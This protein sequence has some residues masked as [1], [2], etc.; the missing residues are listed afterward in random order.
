MAGHFFTV[1]DEQS[2]GI[3]ERI[4]HA[5]AVF[6]IYFCNHQFSA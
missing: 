5:P 2:V 4:S 6:P 1:P 3:A